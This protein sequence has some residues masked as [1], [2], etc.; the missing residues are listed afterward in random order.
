M[1]DYRCWVY[2]QTKAPKIVSKEVAEQLY[3]EGW[4]DT[5]AEFVN[6]KDH[7]VELDDPF[8]VQQV[9]DAVDGVADCLN[10]ELNLEL[11]NKDQL[12]DYAKKHLGIDIDRRKG[13]KRLVEEVRTALNK[14][15]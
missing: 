8:K 12:E 6:W 15:D 5:P 14:K 1:S 9:V 13:L 7:G 10:G 4:A 2:H 3:A 11:M